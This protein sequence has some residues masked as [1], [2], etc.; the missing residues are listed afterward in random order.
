MSKG[1]HSLISPVQEDR[2]GQGQGQGRDGKT[3]RYCRYICA[4]FSV[5][6]LILLAV[7]EQTSEK[8][9]KNTVISALISLC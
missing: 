1:A 6:V 8:L 3:C 2:Q 4:I 5:A 7:Y 9:A